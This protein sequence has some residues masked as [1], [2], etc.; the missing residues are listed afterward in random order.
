MSEAIDCIN[1]GELEARARKLL[2]QMAYDYY[3][4]GANDEITLRE[5]Q[6][7]YERLA[8][9]PHMLVDV[10]VRDMGTTVLGQT[11]VDAD[12]DCPYG[13]SRPCTLRWRN[14]HDQGGRRR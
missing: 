4:S 10:S 13:A 9:F 11:C 12:F 5:N 8:L 1:L 2:P 6:A 7:A 3:G 14:C